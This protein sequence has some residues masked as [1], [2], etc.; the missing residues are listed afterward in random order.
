MSYNYAFVKDNVNDITLEDFKTAMAVCI[1]SGISHIAPLGC[2]G[3]NFCLYG[4]FLSAEETR[5][6][7]RRQSIV[8]VRNYCGSPEVLISNKSGK[9]LYYGKYYYIGFD[10]MANEYFRIFTM[11]KDKIDEDGVDFEELEIKFREDAEVDDKAF[12]L[13]DRYCNNV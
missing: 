10:E 4:K 3:D 7:W 11:L 12:K 1:K 9:T 6:G 8:S 2:S 5:D 13:L